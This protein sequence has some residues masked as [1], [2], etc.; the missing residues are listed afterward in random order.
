MLLL[1]KKTT[2]KA[3]YGIST[4]ESPRN[5]CDLIKLPKL[6]QVLLPV[7]KQQQQQQ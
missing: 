3:I 7:K 6:Q 1:N 2:C 4:E 5:I